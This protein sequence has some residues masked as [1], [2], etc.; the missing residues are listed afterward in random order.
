MDIYLVL[1]YFCLYLCLYYRM[2]NFILYYKYY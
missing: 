2:D 1:I